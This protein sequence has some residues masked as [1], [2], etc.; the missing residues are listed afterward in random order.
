MKVRLKMKNK[1]R[2]YDIN[3]PMPRHVHN[4][5]KYKIR[6]IKCV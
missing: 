2:R 1:S 6:L 5:A 3:R 4:Y